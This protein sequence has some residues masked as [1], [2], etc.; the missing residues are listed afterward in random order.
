MVDLNSVR[1]LRRDAD[2]RVGDRWVYVA[3]FNADIVEGQGC[4]RIDSEI[5]DLRFLV[6]RGAKV[7]LL[8][9]K[10]RYGNTESLKPAR[11]YLVKKLDIDGHRVQCFFW[12]SLDT[13]VKFSDDLGSGMISIMGTRSY[14]GE[15]KNDDELAKQ[16]ARLGDRVAIGGFGKAHRENASNFGILNYS[17]GYLCESQLEEMRKLNEWSGK[18]KDFSV[19]VLGGVKKEKISVGLEGFVKT[20]DAIIPGGVVL[21]AI[22]KA[23]GREIGGSYMGEVDETVVERVKEILVEV[24]KQR[25][26]DCEIYVPN[27]VIVAR[28]SERGYRDF[29]NVNINV[30]CVP[31]SHMIVSYFLPSNAGRA[32]DRVVEEGGR[33]ILAGTPDLHGSGMEGVTNEVVERM[34]SSGVQG[35]VL[36]GDSAKEVDYDNF[37]TGG[38]SALHFVVNGTTPVFERLQKQM[39]ESGRV[40]LK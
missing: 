14:E 21:N 40:D 32:L 31:E 26:N 12:S 9:S 23:Q 36:G 33:I 22:L 16:F 30:Q 7:T 8:T 29:K 13:A 11:D 38:G 27:K 25:T 18:S 15:E 10:G 6:D 37:S 34:K 28:K 24:Q 3:D 19:A 20:Y 2:V 35:I 4:P 17:E 5:E 39:G 1:H